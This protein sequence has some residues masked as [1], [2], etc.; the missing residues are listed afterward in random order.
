KVTSVTPRP[1]RSP[2]PSRARRMDG[3]EAAGVR[4]ALRHRER[5]AAIAATRPD[6]A[7]TVY[8]NV[9]KGGVIAAVLTVAAAATVKF[10]TA[11]K[12]VFGTLAAR[13][14]LWPRSRC[15]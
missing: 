7:A 9:A 1:K 5:A 15:Y 8:W 12:Q 2:R 11:L 10:T 3:Q 14:K 6:V 13:L 4:E